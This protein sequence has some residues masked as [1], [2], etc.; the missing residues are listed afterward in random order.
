M[1][2]G[3]RLLELR[4]KK[5]ISQ[6]EASNILN[7]SRQ[8]ISKWETGE[9]CPDFDKILPLCE[10]YGITPDE[11][12]TGKKEVELLEVGDKKKIFAKNLGISVGLYIFSIVLI[13]LFA[14]V[15]NQPVIG[16]CL[17]FIVL[18]VATGL[19]V[20]TAINYSTKKE[21]TKEDKTTKLVCEIIDILGVI[22]YFV[23]SFL[24]MAWHIT[25]IIFLII[26]LCEAIAKLLLSLKENREEKTNE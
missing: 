11:L 3:E 19:I 9:S 14:V 15:F 26:G 1:T 2:V 4:K 12:I 13:I 22:I 24:T 8:T 6:E 20:Y 16:V 10:L 21:E 17:F 25:W 5:G 18:A 23:V 7:V